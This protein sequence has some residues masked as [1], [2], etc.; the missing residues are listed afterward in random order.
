MGSNWYA[1]TRV[2]SPAAAA[3]DRRARRRRLRHRRG[4]CRPHRR[5]RGG[6]ARLVGRRAGGA[7]HRL[8]CSGRNTGVVLPGFGAQRRRA[9]RA[10]RPRCRP[11]RCGRC[12]RPAPNMCATPPATCRARRCQRRRLAACVENR[13]HPR[14]GARG[15]R[16]WPANSARRSSRGRPTGCARRCIRRAISTGCIIRAASACI[17]SIMRSVLPP[18]PK[19]LARASSRIRRCWRS[20]R[21]ACESASSRRHSRVRAAH[22]V[23]A[24]NVHID[25]ARAAIRRHAVADL[26]HD[27]HHRAARRRAARCHPLSRRGERRPIRPATTIASWTA[28]PDVVAARARSGSASRSAM[29]MR[30]CARSGAPIRRSATSRRS[31]PGSASPAT[32]CMACRRSAKSRPV[33]GCSSGFGGHGLNTTAMG[34]EM[35]ARAIVEGDRTWEMFSP[36]A[37]V[38]AGGAFGRAAQQVSDGRAARATD[39]TACWRAAREAQAPARRSAEAG[40]R[41]AAG[42]SRTWRRRSSRW[43]N[44]SCSRCGRSS[45]R[46]QPPT[47]RG[48]D[49]AEMTG[50]PV[51]RRSAADPRRAGRTGRRQTAE[52]WPEK[53]EGWRPR[54]SRTCPSKSPQAPTIP[55]AARSA[56]RI[57]CRR[58]RQKT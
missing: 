45:P 39:R 43:P 32:P 5:A 35:V 54:R 51:G 9:D 8:E 21:R 4:A 24:G 23:L 53:E 58:A 31:T 22:V 50:G 33:C 48:I 55:R 11:R 20:I 44:R 28:P 10:R 26:Q 16:C 25:G 34:G 57:G 7:K 37:L 2:E 13:R 30:C 14:D 36:F 15:G 6:A 46:R 12:P 41:S 52:A 38:W 1:A 3:A 18:R 19:P 47:D 27:D 40:G 17:R 56:G 42:R 49:C 29:P